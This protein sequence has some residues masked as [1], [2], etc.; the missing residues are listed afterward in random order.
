MKS[1]IMKQRAM[2]YAKLI[3]GDLF[4]FVHDSGDT[5]ELY[6]ATDT[7]DFEGCRV[8]RNTVKTELSSGFYAT[9]VVRLVTK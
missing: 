7:F 4:V 9:A 8:S 6:E 5:N 1:V 2:S 3:P